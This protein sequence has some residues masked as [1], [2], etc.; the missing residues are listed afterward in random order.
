MWR[1]AITAMQVEN[2]FDEAEW[3]QS[4]F[5]RCCKGAVCCRVVAQH[6]EHEESDAGVLPASDSFWRT[7]VD[8]PPTFP[9]APRE[10]GCRNERGLG[11]LAAS[12]NSGAAGRRQVLF[13]RKRKVFDSGDDAGRVGRMADIGDRISDVDRAQA[14]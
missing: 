10:L 12:Q 1:F 7:A 2:V 13:L 3:T 8:T 11:V 6:A 9:K 14:V 5:S 4:P